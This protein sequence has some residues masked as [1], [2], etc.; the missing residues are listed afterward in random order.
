MSTVSIPELS[1]IIPLLNE[2]N[3]LPHLFDSLDV[4]TGLCYE[5][6]F[7]DGGS[8][9]SS[10]SLLENYAKNCCHQVVV[11]SGDPGRGRQMNQGAAAAKSERL[12]F[13]HADSF[14]QQATLLQDAANCFDQLESEA[15]STPIAAH[16]SLNFNGPECHN[17]FYRY[18]S[19]KSQLNRA[20]TIY[21]DQGMLLSKKLW[22]EIG[23]FSDESI[24][25]EDVL[26][27]EQVALVGHWVLLPQVIFTSNRRYQHEGCLQRVIRN[28][29]MLIIAGAGFSHL[30]SS[31]AALSGGY[32]H[33][34]RN[35]KT[36][37]SLASLLFRMSLTQYR[38]FWYNCGRVIAQHAWLVIYVTSWAVPLLG[39]GQ[40]QE[41]LSFYDRRVAPLLNHP[42]IY[43]VFAILSW[44][45]FYLFCLCLPL[46]WLIQRIGK[47]RQFP[48]EHV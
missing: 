26:F 10:L 16:F 27:V 34:N 6:I 14:W 5:V 9:D 44:F 7:C 24:I 1:L 42:I 47:Q 21:G 23:G 41:I 11:L 40:R 2:E 45:L 29:L 43:T 13:L 20:G 36:V 4:Q 30:L 22:R 38:G 19:E 25:L 39:C 15:R 46:S 33:G 32:H 31:C 3:T 48:K 37:S 18:L 17:R 12:L 35:S 8:K 28:G